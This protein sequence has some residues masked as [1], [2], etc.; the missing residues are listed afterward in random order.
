MALRPVSSEKRTSYNPSTW[1]NP[2]Y[3]SLWGY[4]N[5]GW[6]NPYILGGV[7]RDTVVTV[8]ATIYSVPLNKLL[9]AAVSETRNPDGLQKFVEDLVKEA[10]KELHKQGLA[11]EHRQ[12]AWPSAAQRPGVD[13][14]LAGGWIVW[15]ASGDDE[16]RHI[17]AIGHHR[18]D[19]VEQFVGRCLFDHVAGSPGA[20]G[21]GRKSR[22][23]IDGQDDETGGRS[24]G[25]ELPDGVEAAHDRH[26]HIGH[27][28]IG[29]K[30]AGALDQLATVAHL[31]NQLSRPGEQLPQRLADHGMVVGEEHPRFHDSSLEA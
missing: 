3:S 9:W 13:R 21:R 11:R 26:R 14:R 6:S 17:E 22:I 31:S 12:I 20:H 2:Y 1:A 16:R 27:Y 30:L 18:L 10:V 28:D 19:S 4:Y 23:G 24:L 7:T 5:Y 25:R 15:L 8:E 29:L